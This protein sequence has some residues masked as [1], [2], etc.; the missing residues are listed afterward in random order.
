MTGVE[1]VLRR[2]RTKARK[3][4]MER[5]VAGRSIVAVLAEASAGANECGVAGGVGFCRW[6]LRHGVPMARREVGGC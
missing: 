2:S 5:G 1:R 4:M 6:V 3:K